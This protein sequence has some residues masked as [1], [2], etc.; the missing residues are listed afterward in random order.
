MYQWSTGGLIYKIN[1]K[2]PTNT[3]SPTIS[4]LSLTL[5]SPCTRQK[6]IFLLSMGLI[7]VVQGFKLS[8]TKFDNFLMA[9]GLNPTEGYRLFPHEAADVAKL[10]R[11]K[12]VDC[13]ARVFVPYATGFNNSQYLFV[14]CDWIFVLAA[15]EIEGELQKPVPPAFE[16]LRRSL[17]AE[18]GVSRYV[19]YDEDMSWTPEE[20]IRR[21]TV[22]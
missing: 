5:P 1:P 2:F 7:A 14:C 18:S 9:N 10:F 12:G 20:L 8:V 13:E 3:L 21:N 6:S 16:G 15:R 17:Q 11:A 4:R 22:N 19:V